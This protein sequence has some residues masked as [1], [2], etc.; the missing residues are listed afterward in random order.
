MFTAWVKV[1]VKNVLGYGLVI[2]GLGLSLPGIPGPGTALAFAGL[3]IADWPG[4]RRFFRRMRSFRWF[5]KFDDWFHRKFG[6]RM[7][8]H[9]DE[10]RRNNNGTSRPEVIC[11]VSRRAGEPQSLSNP[12]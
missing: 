12:S 10:R 11:E 5:K 3:A 2:A 9:R 6:M 4:K 8:E 1:I 7:P